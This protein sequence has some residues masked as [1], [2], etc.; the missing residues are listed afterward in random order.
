M[1]RFAEAVDSRL[2]LVET[3]SSMIVM[4]GLLEL[5][6]VLMLRSVTASYSYHE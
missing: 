1:T 2:I 5:G 6:A 4:V 3:G